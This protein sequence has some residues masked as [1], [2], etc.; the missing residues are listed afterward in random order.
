MSNEVVILYFF[1]C[2][3]PIP[4]F[5]LFSFKEKKFNRETIYN[6]QWKKRI[7]FRQEMA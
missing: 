6:L 7:A 2:T 1:F 3:P 5:Q 4:H